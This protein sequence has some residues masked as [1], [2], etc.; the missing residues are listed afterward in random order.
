MA[1]YKIIQEKREELLLDRKIL[2]VEVVILVNTGTGERQPLVLYI[3]N[4][5]P[6]LNT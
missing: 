4:S 5:R 6:L 2:V 3:L 1:V